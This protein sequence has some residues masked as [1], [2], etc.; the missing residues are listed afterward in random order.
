LTTPRRIRRITIL[1]WGS[2]LVCLLVLQSLVTAGAFW[3]R[4]GNQ[5]RGQ[6]HAEL[7]NRCTTLAKL[8]PSARRSW[9]AD[10]LVA[11]IHR[12]NFLALFDAGGR[13]LAGNLARVP[14]LAA[15]TR[16]SRIVTL[17][18]TN[19]PGVTVDKA[20]AMR[21]AMPDGTIV[22]AGVDLDHFNSA[23]RSAEQAVLVTLP[24]AFLLAILVG[25]GVAAQ[26]GRR[27][28][29]VR[30]LSEKIVA[31]EFGRRLP[32][33]RR[34]DSFQMLCG[35]I[36]TMLDRIE[37]LMHEVRGVGDDIAHELRTPLTR[38]RARVERQMATARSADDFEHAADT[39]LKEIS[40]AEGLVSALLRIR[41]IEHH[42]KRFSFQD[43]ALEKI[44]GDV[45][46]LYQP[47]AENA[48]KRLILT[49][50]PR[51]RVRGDPD[52]L[53]EALS[54][55]VDN[56]LKFGPAASTVEVT[57]EFAANHC[58]RF[59]VADRGDAI[60]VEDRTR[61]FQRFYRG[62]TA[63]QQPGSGLGL[64][65]VKAI[66][67]LHDIDVFFEARDDAAGKLAVLQLTQTCK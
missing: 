4:V 37:T 6:I 61:V 27:L 21:C 2:G 25:G 26:A 28:D 24:I 65:L 20:R 34:S 31:G 62:P 48:G 13:V 56:A 66:A 3:Y 36:N 38:L 22:V 16:G 54:N 57:L 32:V 5:E 63:L 19:L 40:Q 55:L 52:L 1:R 45:V 50:K 23:L 30:I 47:V 44:A 17:Q 59:T 12:Q 39:V 51:C 46:E 33:G 43:V 41:E 35:H 53:M 14:D 7:H 11:D 29:T 60:A 42:R 15:G 67:E 18:P 49:A 9:I 58:P 10:T 64:S 8:A